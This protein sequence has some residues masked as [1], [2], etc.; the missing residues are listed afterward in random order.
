MGRQVLR[1]VGATQGL[2][3]FKEGGRHVVH[4]YNMVAGSSMHGPSY[5]VLKNSSNYVLIG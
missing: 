4:I 3:V 1:T 5:N 2:L